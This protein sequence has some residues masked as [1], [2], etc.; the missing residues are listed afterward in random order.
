MSFPV[1]RRDAFRSPKSVGCCHFLDQRNCLK[2]APRLPRTRLGFVL[3]EP[4]EKF[5]MEAEQHLRLNQEERLFPGSNHLGEEYQQ[6]P[7]FLLIHRAF[8]LSM[9]DEQLVA[10]AS[11]FLPAVRLCLW[12]NRRVHQPWGR[13]LVALSTA[14]HVLEAHGSRKRRMA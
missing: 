11:R 4:T 2:R 3:P 14:K 6:K 10:R 5:T 9:Q 7:V 8:D 12:S 13:S 1:C